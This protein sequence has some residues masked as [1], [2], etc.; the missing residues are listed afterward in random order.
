VTVAQVSPDRISLTGRGEL[1]KRPLTLDS[2]MVIT[3]IAGGWEI[4]P[5]RVRFGGGRGR[6]SG[7]TG[8]RPEFRA[9]IER[10]PL[11]LLDLVWPKA[12]L[13]GIASGRVE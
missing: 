10:M 7:R 3:R 11:Q 4:A 8:D 12:G 1:A 6:L 5:T 2:P 13:G 9:D